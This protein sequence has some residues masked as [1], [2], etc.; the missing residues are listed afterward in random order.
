M[1]NEAS[2]LAIFISSFLLGASTV[3]A[4]ATKTHA[5]HLLP[6]ST[7]IPMAGGPCQ[8]EWPAECDYSGGNVVSR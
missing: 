8:D 5:N 4:T 3:S 1:V 2:V 7:C 6:R